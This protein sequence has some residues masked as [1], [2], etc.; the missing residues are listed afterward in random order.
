MQSRDSYIEQKSL[1]R[2]SLKSALIGYRLKK[3]DVK[4]SFVE[5]NGSPSELGVILHRYYMNID[6]IDLLISPGSLEYVREKP[7]L[8]VDY[9]DKHNNPWKYSKASSKIKSYYKTHSYLKYSIILKGEGFKSF[10]S[11]LPNPV[12]YIYI[13][14]PTLNKLETYLV[15][16]EDMHIAGSRILKGVNI[17]IDMLN[18]DYDKILTR[19]YKPIYDDME[20][21]VQS[22]L[23]NVNLK[24]LN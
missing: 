6:L 19:Y 8:A 1:E 18:I 10:I 20:Y 22:D 21:I 7:A 17:E 12:D 16:K 15:K 11:D 3:G 13:Y 4:F 14:N 5:R 9:L 23:E 2:E 24:D